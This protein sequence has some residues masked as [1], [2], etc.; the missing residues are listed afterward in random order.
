MKDITKRTIGAISLFACGLW[1]HIVAADEARLTSCIREQVL[2][3]IDMRA[4]ES[5]LND[6]DVVYIGDPDGYY[7][8]VN[9][10]RLRDDLGKLAARIKRSPALMDRVALISGYDEMYIN[11][12]ISSGLAV[13][14]AY[15]KITANDANLR[16][17]EWNKLPV[18]VAMMDELRACVAE[19]MGKRDA[20]GGGARA[21]MGQAYC[22]DDTRKPDRL[23]T[24]STPPYGGLSRLPVKGS[25]IC[26]GFKEFLFDTGATLQVYKCDAR[27]V[28]ATCTYQEEFPYERST[29]PDTGV[30]TLDM[31]SAGGPGWIDLYPVQ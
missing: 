2:L 30:V 20:S 23:A 24:W 1:A 11:F 18:Y 31:A 26:S 10:H 3:E 16:E 19:E 25:F 8:P 12:L 6:M 15:G 28:D 5:T 7:F 9:K 29:D 13:G 17:K 14:T 4:T 22:F 21:G 27:A